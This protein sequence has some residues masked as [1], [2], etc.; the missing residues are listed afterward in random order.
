MRT[1]SRTRSLGWS[2][3]LSPGS[4]PLRPRPRARC[5][6]RATRR[7]VARGRRSI[8]NTAHSASSWRGTARAAA[9]SPPC[10]RATRRCAPR[11]D[12]RRRAR[13]FSGG[14]SKSPITFTRC[15]STPSAE[16]LVKPDG[17]TRRT[18]AWSGSP[19]P[20]SSTS[21]SARL[22]AHGVGG[23]HVDHELDVVRIADL[24][25]AASPGVHDACALLQDAQHAPGDRR[26][27]ADAGASPR[28]A[29]ARGS[30]GARAAALRCSSRASSAARAFVE[31]RRARCGSAC[32]R[33]LESRARDRAALRRSCA[34]ALALGAARARPRACATRAH[35][36]AL[37]RRAASSG[38]GST[39]LDLATTVSPA[40]P[41]RP[42]RARCGAGGPA[43][44]R[45]HE[46]LRAR[47]SRPPRPRSRCSG[48][49]STSAGRRP[50]AA[51]RNSQRARAR[52]ARSAARARSASARQRHRRYSRVF[53][54]ATR[55]SWSSRRRTI[56]AE[57]TSHAAIAH[58]RA[59][60]GAERARPACGRLPS[61]TRRRS[62]GTAGADPEADG[63][64]EQRRAAP[65]RRAGC[66]D[67]AAREAEHAQARELARRAPRARRARSCR[68]RRRRCM[69]AK[70]TKNADEDAAVSWRA[71]RRSSGGGAPQRARRRP[72]AALEL[73]AAAARAAA[74]T[75]QVRAATTSRS[76]ISRW[77][78]RLHVG[79]RCPKARRTVPTTGSV[80]RRPFALEDLDRQLLARPDAEISASWSRARRP[81]GGIAASP[82]RRR[83]M[84]A[85]CAPSGS[86]RIGYAPRRR[87]DAEARRRRAVRLGREHAGQPRELVR[88]P[89]AAG[90]WKPTVTSSRWTARNWTS[91][92]CSIASSQKRRRPAGSR[93]RTRRRARRR[94]A[95]PGQ[96]AIVAPDHAHRRVEARARARRDALARGRA[97]GAARA[98]RLGGRERDRAAHRAERAE[99]RRADERSRRPRSRSRGPGPKHEQR[100]AVEAR[101]TC[102]SCCARARAP[103]AD[104]DQ[105]AER[106]DRDHAARV[107]Q[108][109]ARS[110]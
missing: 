36:R 32:L 96:R 66:G 38:V 10:R 5:G 90:S 73:A 12:S 93:P 17:S 105:R 29:V 35:P 68:R 67:L 79:V 89:R 75:Q 61:R 63:K 7:A 28:A 49:R 109:T 106:R 45:P 54:T 56:T 57:T 37:P 22:D 95:R 41:R 99:Q 58:G 14:R 16:T 31:R 88:Q 72:P 92:R 2:T 11:P 108:P 110:V 30:C 43:T 8:T 15:S 100:E 62:A 87:P 33:R 42:P 19:P 85:S 52:G 97:A 78:A 53:S 81:R 34:L 51:G 98:H 47:A 9:A 50:P 76:R 65:A 69:D 101:R 70:K 13:H 83:R 107:V 103:S 40:T 1:P 20:Q 94:T 21:T 77:S 102:R 60:R 104:A 91:I 80:E 44:A 39:R 55:S 18:R 27:H 48:P 84:V 71:S 26:A 64:A 6:G 24:E 3:T 25:R 86:P 74:S 4:S 82:S 59:E 46:A 23:E